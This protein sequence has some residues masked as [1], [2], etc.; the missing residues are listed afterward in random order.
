M[1]LSLGF[2]ADLLLKGHRSIIL[3]LLS[4]WHLRRPPGVYFSFERKAL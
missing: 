3:C 4:V 1:K 2:R